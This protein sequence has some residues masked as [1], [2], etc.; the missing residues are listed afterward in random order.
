M[1]LVTPD[2]LR[3]L[4]E[5]HRQF[6]RGTSP[7][8]SVGSLGPLAGLVRVHDGWRDDGPTRTHELLEA[9][10]RSTKEAQVGR[11]Y[12][13][14]T[15]ADVVDVL[16]ARWGISGRSQATLP[17]TSNQT[18]RNWSSRVTASTQA[19]V[20]ATEAALSIGR[21][22]KE[23]NPDPER[24]T[25]PIDTWTHPS[26]I[27]FTIATSLISKMPHQEQFSSEDITQLLRARIVTRLLDYARDDDA[28]LYRHVWHR[29][30]APWFED[31]RYFN[32]TRQPGEALSPGGALRRETEALIQLFAF[33]VVSESDTRSLEQAVQR[34]DGAKA[35]GRS[36]PASYFEGVTPI[37]ELLEPANTRGAFARSRLAVL[38]AQ[39][40]MPAE[41]G[42]FDVAGTR[43]DD[44]GAKALQ[45]AYF[46]RNAPSDTKAE[47][48]RKYVAMRHNIKPPS[49]RS[50]QNRLLALA[51]QSVGLDAVETR[52][53]QLLGWV[54]EA[55]H[56]GEYSE[57][58]WA[59]SAFT[60][61][62]RA[63]LL[64]KDGDRELALA[65]SIEAWR[66]TDWVRTAELSTDRRALTEAGHQIALGAAGTCTKIVEDALIDP[67]T[68]DRENMQSR[69]T[70]ALAWTSYAMNQLNILDRADDTAG[71][72]ARRHQDGYISSI[73]W[74]IQ[75]RIIRTRALLGAYTAAHSGLAQWLTEPSLDSLRAAYLDIIEAQETKAS[76][77]VD[78][79][80]LAIWLGFLSNGFVPFTRHL[81]P[82]LK[83][84]HFIDT[85][86]D[87][88][89]GGWELRRM[90]FSAASE[91]LL[92]RNQDSGAPHWFSPTSKAYALL[93]RRTGGQYE[94]WY[95][96]MRGTV[97]RSV[98]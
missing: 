81:A 20:L 24:F 23:A 6:L 62:D 88:I 54:A 68:R 69:I 91:W 56:G 16:S 66:H 37:T 10:L 55:T 46:I 89:D 36:I 12:G 47:M 22:N 84:L 26:S 85:D 57:I 14:T 43:S 34:R 2:Q 94:R 44:V 93:Q 59:Y 61:R 1:A 31:D 52:N 87:S 40:Q 76:T 92:A 77:R 45:D 49:E 29:V 38:M 39:S 63:L 30:F 13:E 21:L 50:I 28:K 8:P 15:L 3:A 98:N 97:R 86:P 7:R 72:A 48:I 32:T 64:G 70:A 53:P 78:V 96:G 17:G 51:D 18:A 75:T 25:Y 73:D 82:A 33:S 74:R 4:I 83:D 19:R 80:K 95:V 71:L 67:A 42:E 90:N 79:T 41:I 27:P 11:F 35:F 5:A 9:I 65:K 60:T 58:R